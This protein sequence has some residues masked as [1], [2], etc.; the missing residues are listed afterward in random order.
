MISIT[1]LYCRKDTSGDWLRY[2]S[3]ARKEGISELEYALATKPIV[4]WNCTR[5]CNLRCIHCY[6]ESENKQY[7]GEL[8]TDQAKG[9]ID[10]LAEFGVPVLLFSGGEPLMRSDLFLLAEYAR[11][12][13]IRTVI[14]TNG[15]LIDKNQAR[16][17]KQ[18]GISYVGISLDGLQKTN[19]RFR[20]KKGAF[21]EALHGIHNCLEVDQKVGLRF[22]ISKRNYDDIPGIFDLVESERIPRLCFYHLAYCGRGSKLIDEDIPNQLKRELIEY[23][24]ARSVDLNDKGEYDILTVDNHCDGVYIYLKLL[25]EDPARAEAV[26][27]LLKIN[28]GNRSGIAIADVDW[29]G[30]VHA[31]QFWLHYSFGNIRDRKFGDIWSDLS[32][33]LMRG[34]KDRSHLLKGRCAACKYKDLCNGNLRVRAEAVY[35]DVWAPDPACYLTDEEIGITL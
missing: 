33:P 26:Y 31:D 20:A 9:F 32:D 34:L 30:S 6:S 17:I 11:I 7:H 12:K 18:A 23:I 15:T 10:Q 21:A 5:R 1:K 25:K 16:Q 3:R 35:Q 2:Q 24:L 22:T 4:V 14:S 13:G 19:D 27:G 29:N 28:R 8:T